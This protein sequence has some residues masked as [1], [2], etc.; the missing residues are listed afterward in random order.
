MRTIL[1]RWPRR[2]RGDGSTPPATRGSTSPI[3]TIC[4]VTKLLSALGIDPAW[5][6]PAVI[7]LIMIVALVGWYA[8]RFG[9]RQIAGRVLARQPQDADALVPQVELER[10]VRT[11]ERT[12]VR[13]GGVII[14]IVAV[15]MA[16]SSGFEIDIGPAIAG[17]GIVG[18]AVGFGAQTLIRDWLAG[19]FV[20]LENQYNQGD[21]V[22]IAG[23]SGVVEDF[24]LRRTALRDLDGTV[25]TVPNGQIT[26][27]SNLT[28]VWAR[29]N[30]DIP[31]A[32][33]TDIDLATRLIND[34]GAQ[35]HADPEWAGR[36]LAAPSVVWVGHFGDTG[37][38]L[39]VLGQVPAAEQWA[40]AGELRKRILAAF[41]ERGIRIPT[42]PRVF[43][44]ATCGA[45]PGA[46]E[47]E[48]SGAQTA[49]ESSDP[50]APA[51]PPRS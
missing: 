32:Y 34:V 14:V 47:A 20:V 5:T 26:V 33:D 28:R 45:T 36:L 43:V 2:S 25:H 31:V 13:T 29:V 21:V 9:A 22:R 40:V 11:L 16:L 15:L 44:T 6:G 24:S 17:L 1:P 7:L 8:L 27:A 4:L 51:G 38:S 12:A 39:K 48:S 23:V 50:T 3:A 19:I 46:L 42:A 30:V 37:D 18:I 10:R 35:L 49:E 41:A